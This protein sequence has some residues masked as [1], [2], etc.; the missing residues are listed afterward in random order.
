MPAPAGVDEASGSVAMRPRR[1]R[2]T[3]AGAASGRAGVAQPAAGTMSGAVC[4]TTSTE[5]GRA[6]RFAAFR[7]TVRPRTA[8]RVAAVEPTEAA[9]V[10]DRATGRGIAPDR[11]PGDL[12][13]S[14]IGPGTASATP[15]RP[16]AE[17]PPAA[18]SIVM[19]RVARADDPA[20]SA[21]STDARPAAPTAPGAT[22]PLDETRPGVATRRRRAT[23][24]RDPTRARDG[25]RR[26]ARPGPMVRGVATPPHGANR[27]AARR[28]RTDRASPRLT[29]CMTTRSWSPV[30]A[31]SRRPSSPVDRPV[32]FSSSRSV[33]RRS[34]G[35]SSMR[36]RSG[37]RS[38]RSRAER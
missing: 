19:T 13:P 33:A 25:M 20:G 5:A 16:I 21:R 22:L 6:R 14:T 31:R 34:S 11:R 26:G 23:M 4:V 36:R 15:A 7:Q 17:V 32:A 37:S 38:W 27:S 18:R 28:T 29:S 24:R 1:V 30:G 10:T 8:G 12:A 3:A 9:T 35:S 2:T